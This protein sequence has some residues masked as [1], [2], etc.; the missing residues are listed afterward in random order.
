MINFIFFFNGGQADE[1]I[2]YLDI[3]KNISSKSLRAHEILMFS[4]NIF[5]KKYLK[6]LAM[7][8]RS[9]LNVIVIAKIILNGYT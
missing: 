4:A 6:Y 1:T 7:S 9:I 8:T 3:K 2:L 5:Q